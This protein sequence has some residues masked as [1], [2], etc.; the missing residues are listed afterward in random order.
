MSPQSVAPADVFVAFGISGDLARKMTFESLYRLERRGELKCPVIGVAAEDW[1]DD[2]LRKHARESLQTFTKPADLENAVVERLLARM[3]Y[4]G[5]DLG[6]SATFAKV[7]TAVGSAALPVFYLELPPMLFGPVVQGLATAG[8]TK[9]ARVVVEKPFGHD[10]ESA[11]ALNA[12]LTSL[13]EESQIYR[14]DHFLAKLSVQ[15]LLH[16]RFA[17]TVLEPLWNRQYVDNVQITLAESF[18]VADRGAFYDRVGALRDVIQ[19]HLMQVLAMVAMEPPALEGPDALS[20]RKLDVFSAIPSVDPAQYVRGQ[21]DGYLQTK[22]VAEG[23]KT[24]TYAAL[25][26]QVEN[27]RWAGVPFFVRAGKSMAV[28]STEVR[29]VFKTPPPL[30]FAHFD[31]GAR[32]NQLVLSVDPT[33]GLR[34]VLQAK[35][36]DADGLQDVTLDDNLTRDSYSPTP[37]EEL[38][39]AAMVGDRSLF[40]REDGLEETWRILGPVLELD[41]APE[42]YAPKSWG[43]KAAD[44]LT[45]DAGGWQEPWVF[46]A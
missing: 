31:D 22:G 37:Y 5:G 1:S 25:R 30:Y 12:Q 33:P 3:S 19:N 44:A 24:E 46:T 15:D 32:P 34:L 40:T 29:V 28:T 9:H 42:A 2:D 17:N 16:L 27:W 4:V 11:K 38:L 36:P 6:D 39:S 43:P 45:A 23:S 21:Y 10:L 35:R 13:L 7:A 41:S 18:D 14:I 8:L 26:L 20:D